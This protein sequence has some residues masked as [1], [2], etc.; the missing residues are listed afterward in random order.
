ME[1]NDED[2]QTSKG[3][4]NDTVS[5]AIENETE[6]QEVPPSNNV[7]E[8]DK[9]IRNNYIFGEPIVT[10]VEVALNKRK[11]MHKYISLCCFGTNSYYPFCSI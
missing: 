4:Q 1:V 9:D 5:Q 3:V 8:I 7:K 10:L 2:D 6:K 11:V